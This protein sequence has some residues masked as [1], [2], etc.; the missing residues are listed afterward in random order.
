[1]VNLSLYGVFRYIL[2]GDPYTQRIRVTNRSYPVSLWDDYKKAQKDLE[3]RNKRW[4]ERLGKRLRIEDEIYYC[5]PCVFEVD[6]FKGHFYGRVYDCLVEV[7]SDLDEREII[8]RL[9][10]QSPSFC[11][12]QPVRIRG[13]STLVYEG[14]GK[15]AEDLKIVVPSHCTF[16]SYRRRLS[17]RD[18]FAEKIAL[19]DVN[20]SYGLVKTQMPREICI[21]FPV[22][23]YHLKTIQCLWDEYFA[24]AGSKNEWLDMLDYLLEGIEK[25]RK[26]QSNQNEMM[27]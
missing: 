25:Q 4:Q 1:M 27:P 18:C 7:L 10:S 22:Y 20:G 16:L 24:G 6:E 17:Y 2:L 9:E 14:I 3:A 13:Y 21:S 5:K 23:L 15:S 11:L 12:P 26:R 8:P 19:H